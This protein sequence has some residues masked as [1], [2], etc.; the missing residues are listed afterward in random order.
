MYSTLNMML[1]LTATQLL[2]HKK[3]NRRWCIQSINMSVKMQKI[4]DIFP[5]KKYRNVQDDK[6]IREIGHAISTAND[7]CAPDRWCGQ[8]IRG[9]TTMH[10][11]NPHYITLHFSYPRR[12][13]TELNENSLKKT[14]VSEQDLC[15]LN[16][17]SQANY[18]KVLHFKHYMHVMQYTHI[19]FFSN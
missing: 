2:C 3:L 18:I 13:M 15:A 1:V 9:S 14:D 7:F 5:K 6:N 17:K 12:N 11:I 19:I 4:H 10:Y 8:R 16:S